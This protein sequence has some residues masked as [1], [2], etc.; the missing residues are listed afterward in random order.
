MGSV[1]IKRMFGG[2]GVYA[3]GVMFAAGLRRHHSYLKADDDA[4][5]NT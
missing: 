1:Q 2:A 5:S 4:M 3:D